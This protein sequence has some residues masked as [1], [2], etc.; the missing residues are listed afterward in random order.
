MTS[1]Q[2]WLDIFRFSSSVR[3]QMTCK[4]R[5]TAVLVSPVQS[6]VQSSPESRFYRDPPTWEVSLVVS[7]KSQWMECQ[8]ILLATSWGKFGLYGFMV[9]CVDLWWGSVFI[10]MESDI[11]IFYHNFTHVNSSWHPALDA[12][13]NLWSGLQLNYKSL[14]ATSSYH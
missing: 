7:I 12:F 3:W 6:I 5:Y 13:L 2:F 1:P 4:S 9:K 10:L 8:V 11:Y 14:V